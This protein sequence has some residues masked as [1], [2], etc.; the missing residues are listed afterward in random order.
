MRDT[1]SSKSCFEMQNFPDLKYIETIRQSLWS[2]GS[3]G[4]PDPED[5]RFGRAAVMIGSGFSRNAVPLHDGAKS[6]PLWRDT[7]GLLIDKLL[8]SSQY[9]DKD[10]ERRLNDSVPISGALRLA[11][12]FEATFG[13]HKLDE[14]LLD[15]IPDSESDPG[16][17]H[18]LL[19]SLPWSDVLT[20]NYDTLL[21]RAAPIHYD[22]V[23]AGADIPRST[24]PR[25]V[26]LHGSFP[27]NR[28]FIF[29]EEDF[30]TYPREFSPFINLAQQTIIENTFCLIGFSGDD[31]NFLNWSG[32]VRDHLGNSAP[33][34]YL[35]GLLNSS[36]SQRRMLEKRNVTSIDLGPMFPVDKFPDRGERHRLAIEW[37]LLCLE[38]GKPPEP[39]DWPEFRDRGLSA[40]S[41]KKIPT[42]PKPKIAVVANE[43]QMPDGQR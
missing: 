28:P 29:T 9:S 19:L 38:A 33:Q 43:P 21:E 39:E 10:R 20:T 1:P 32:W 30:R 34:I 24:R 8:P 18:R 16:Y 37:F 26:K 31:P 42:V 17:M 14:M 25:I 36:D 22:T 15:S 40:P 12:E 2:G 7:V 11:E 41:S 27:S 6:F 4:I 13:R 3:N 35:V 5:G 23:V